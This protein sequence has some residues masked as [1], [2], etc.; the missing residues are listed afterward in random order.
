MPVRG[1]I[2]KHFFAAAVML[3]LSGEVSRKAKVTRVKG[4]SN[5]QS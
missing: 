3:Q 1:P 4:K 2:V 5:N